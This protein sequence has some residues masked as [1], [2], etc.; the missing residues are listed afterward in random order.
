MEVD[1]PAPADARFDATVGAWIL[2]RY[3]DVAEGLVTTRRLVQ[4]VSEPEAWPARAA[5]EAADGSTARMPDEGA[6]TRM[7]QEARSELAPD[8]IRAW[9][10]ALFESAQHA[11]STVEGPVELVADVLEPWCLAAAG[12]VT[13]AP[14]E[15]G[16][17]LLSLA[18]RVLAG[19]AEPADAEL[20]ADA[21]A[22][23]K[24][25]G[26]RLRRHADGVSLAFC[27]PR[28]RG[29]VF[30]ALTR[31]LRAILANGW[32]ALLRRAGELERVRTD[33]GLLA[34]AAEEILRCASV[35]ARLYR[36]AIARPRELGYRPGDRVILE[37]AAANHDP[38]RFEVPEH[39][40]AARPARGHLA[41]GLGPHACSGG[42]LLRACIQA[43]T[44]ALVS[45]RVELDETQ[46]LTWGGGSGFRYVESLR[47]S[48]GELER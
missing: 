23:T 40:D 36:Q 11:F 35:P 1:A 28:S 13:G 26:K 6:Q 41:L 20:A 42:G 7:K 46:L 15:D 3:D 29:R 47:V 18:D 24:M 4:G 43:A 17:L 33:S 25:L 45:R 19:A 12:I 30:V 32:L 5:G 10:G 39:F 37:L 44:A 16:A 22:A 8:R 34:S 31:T 9:R 38:A 14:V 2:S 48:I 21:A 27:S